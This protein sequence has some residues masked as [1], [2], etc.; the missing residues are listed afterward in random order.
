[1]SLAS[2]LLTVLLVG[3]VAVAYAWSADRIVSR[4]EP[5]L[6]GATRW[7]AGA[8]VWIAIVIWAA[9]LAG[10]VGLLSAW[11][12]SITAVVLV[13][14]VYILDRR[15]PV[16]SREIEVSAGSAGS[17][18]R[19]VSPLLLTA[20]LLSTGLAFGAFLAGVG[21][22]IRT[23]MTGFDSTWYH[24]PIAAEISRTGDTLSPHFVAP[25]FLTWFYPH[26]S[27]LLH[28]I[29]L[30]GFGSDFPS[31]MI[32]LALFLGCLLAGWGV[33]RSTGAGPPAMAGVAIIIGAAVFADQAGEAR[34]DLAGTF[35]L[36][37]G[38][39]LAA[40][41]ATRSGARLNGLVLLVALAG[42]LAAGTKL[43]FILPGVVLA[44]GSVFLAPGNGRGRVLPWALGG[45]LL[46][47]AYWYARNLLASGNPLPWITEL[48]PIALP[49]PDQATG[50]RDPG[51][52]I[53]YLT[54]FDVITNDFL[55]GLS[56]GFG[57]G[58]PVIL[59]LALLGVILSFG[60]KLPTGLRIGAV[61]VLAVMASWAFGPT[62]ASGPSG[63]PAGFV[64]GLRYLAP[65]LALGLALLGAVTGA[66]TYLV[67]AGLVILILITAPFA[68][69]AGGEPSPGQLLLAL[70]LAAITALVGGLIA[71]APQRLARAAALPLA[72]VAALILFGV[73]YL[74]QDS[75]ERNRYLEPRFVTTGLADAFA[76][77]RESEPGT[78]IGST[79]TRIY[80]LTN[81][82][83]DNRVFFIG[84]RQSQGGFTRV[85]DCREFIDSVNS[86]SPD[87]LV[88]SL[89]REG[90]KRD[91][92]PEVA[93]LDREPAARPLF[94]R[95]PTAVF[96][97]TG[98]LD[99][100]RC[101]R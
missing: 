62:S 87:F 81:P 90:L 72:V 85:T 27:E 71:V 67:R 98:S 59:I 94:R 99:P 24:G 78:R 13:A 61:T 96:E 45:F 51:S 4:L 74:A 86:Q 58:W 101:R 100:D 75:L 77:A 91:Y 76:W 17:T 93:W 68:V 23:G 47:G 69:F 44:A 89:D 88:A 2:Y 57:E 6:H 12:M 9:L 1:M 92:P 32:N 39:A 79:A 84:R 33:G 30:L 28:S 46:G 34:N 83:L 49:G 55:P 38:V 82:G 3:L 53:S 8:L 43:N 56:E 37:A 18:G 20:A 70:V 35:F 54:D 80:P 48:G 66:R 52:V 31:L 16:R 50:G 5:D 97:L 65:G 36:L 21:D 41:S 64:S 22:R 95:P 7:L 19:P 40:N 10:T 14:I 63:D 73:G 15:A 29:G 42:G 11:S 26:N 60:P 25:Q